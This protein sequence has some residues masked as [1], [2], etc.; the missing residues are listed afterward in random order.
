MQQRDI[1]LHEKQ[2]AHSLKGK[3]KNNHIPRIFLNYV[4]L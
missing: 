4:T 2:P 1:T 3:F